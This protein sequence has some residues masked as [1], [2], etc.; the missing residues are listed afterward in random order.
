[1][2]K[3]EG[4]IY[5]TANQHTVWQDHLAYASEHV[6]FRQDIKL[7]CHCWFTALGVSWYNLK[8]VPIYR[9]RER[10]NKEVG[11]LRL[12]GGSFNKQGKL[13]MGLSWAVNR[14]PAPTHQILNV[15]REALTGVSRVYWPDTLNTTLLTQGCVLG[16]ASGSVKGKLISHSMDR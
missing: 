5:L 11:H 3:M 7:K 15:Y 12:V 14:S 10:Q 4:H 8:L 1:M 16:A 13:L 6:D 9:G 2:L